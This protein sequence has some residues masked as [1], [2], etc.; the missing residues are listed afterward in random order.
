MSIHF[1]TTKNILM[2]A[3]YFLFAFLLIA[4]QISFA[5]NLVDISTAELTAKNVFFERSLQE[6]PVDFQTIRISDSHIRGDVNQSAVYVFNFTNG[7]FVIVPSDRTLPPYIAYA[8]SGF[9]PE[10]GV[11]QTFDSF[12]QSYMDQ[13]DFVHENNIKPLKDIESA[14]ET[15]STTS[16]YGIFENT[17]SRSVAPL[18]NNLWNQDF[19]Y[20]MLCPEDPGGP[21]GHVYA[22]CVA[23]AMSMIMHYWR[24]PLQ[25]NGS[26]GYSWGNYG[27]IFADFGATSYNYNHMKNTM[28]PQMTEAALLQFHCGVAVEMMY[29]PGGS[30]AYSWDVPPA[31]QE[32]F[33]Y[34]PLST[35]RQ[36][37][38]YSNTEWAD[39]LKYQI[40]QG[41]PMYYSG[42]SNSGGHAFVCDGYDDSDFFHYNFGWSGTSNG[43]YS[44][45]QVGGFNSGQGAVTDFIP[46]GNYPY[47]Y[48]E[49]Q[50]VTGK[51]GSIEDGSGPVADYVADDQLSWLISP[52]MPGDSVSN[53]KLTFDKFDISEDDAV[54]VYDGATESAQILGTFTG[55]DLPDNLISTGNQLLVVLLSNGEETANGFV[56]EYTANSPSWCD[57]LSTIYE[58]VGEV[59]D[60]SLHFN[61][62]N[63]TFCRWLISPENPVPSSLYFTAFDT[64]A[65]N[66]PVIIFDA[67]SMER[68]ATISGSYSSDNLPMPVTSQSGEFYIVFTSNSTVN[69]QGW[70]CVYSPDFVGVENLEKSQDDL[71]LYPNPAKDQLTVLLPKA[72][73]NDLQLTIYTIAGA[74]VFNQNNKVPVGEKSLQINTSNYQRG[75]YVVIVWDGDNFYRKELAIY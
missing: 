41:Q 46:A 32:Y 73:E 36:K 68:L 60:G 45:F 24:Y 42:Y 59:H 16:P 27:Y 31:I 56:I 61:Y 69:G 28:D 66:D 51:S 57:N 30:G 26:H 38:D 15:Y 22:G 65:E 3:R 33:G 39:L 7:G 9:C 1:L 14:W 34:S 54:V 49:Q 20:N 2:N 37:E 52:Q 4:F 64:E 21:G 44:L 50:I 23:T 47:H 17:D 19:P 55:S 40:D 67:V 58:S 72:L 35:F 29:S 8:L 75:L 10:Q 74:K 70:E 63:N 5:Q 12:I 53:I 43:F 25:G 18:L 71:Q 62:D 48:T 13:I 6:Q 11:N